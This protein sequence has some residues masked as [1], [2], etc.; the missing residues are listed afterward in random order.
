[1]ILVQVKRLSSSNLWG[2]QHS[3]GINNGL[4]SYCCTRKDALYYPIDSGLRQIVPIDL[5]MLDCVRVR[6]ASSPLEVDVGQQGNPSTVEGQ[7]G[8]DGRGLMY[9]S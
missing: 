3:N 8:P 7:K 2:R 4:Y 1:M 9:P 6:A 5:A